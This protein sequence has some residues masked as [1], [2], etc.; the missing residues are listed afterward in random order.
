MNT[1]LIGWVFGGIAAIWTFIGEE[2]RK[3]LL[4]KLS[5]TK[6]RNTIGADIIEE[7]ARGVEAVY[8]QLD[9]MSQRLSEFATEN[10]RL[11]NI[12]TDN[13]KQKSDCKDHINRLESCIRSFVTLCNEICS[14][15]NLCTG[16]IQEMLKKHNVIIQ[17]N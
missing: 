14:T 11:Y 4:S 5:L 3:Y 12:I 10:E 16:K 8:L 13:N 15:P 7:R 2:K 17:D 1:E 6:E 9:K